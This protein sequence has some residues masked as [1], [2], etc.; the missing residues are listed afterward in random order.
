MRVLREG[1]LGLGEMQLGKMG[2]QLAFVSIAIEKLQAF[3]TGV[4]Q[5]VVD[6]LGQVVQN[7]LRGQSEIA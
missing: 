5:M 4:V 2:N 1:E 3:E 7:R 6:V